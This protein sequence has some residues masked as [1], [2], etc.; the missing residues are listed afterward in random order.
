MGGGCGRI[1]NALNA[2]PKVKGITFGVFGDFSSS[3]STLIGGFAHEGALENPDRLGQ[4]NYKA[5]Y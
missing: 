2:I 4:S 3:M 1:L 5:A